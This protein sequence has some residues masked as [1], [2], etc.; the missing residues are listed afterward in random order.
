MEARGLH[1]TNFN[2]PCYNDA[3]D[4]RVLVMEVICFD[5]KKT[6]SNLSLHLIMSWY[7]NIN[8]EEFITPLVSDSAPHI[9][10]YN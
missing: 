9:P 6:F 1:E 2:T 3:K 8:N 4:L 10:E 5:I 7:R